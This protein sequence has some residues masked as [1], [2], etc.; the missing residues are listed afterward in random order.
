MT[1]QDFIIIYNETFRY[2]EE[3]FGRDKVD[4]LWSTISKQWCTHLRE[5]VEE[6]GLEGMLE[7][8]GGSEGT[9]NREKADYE[10][11]L[12]KGVFTIQMYNCPSVK[13]TKDKNMP[14]YK[15]YC[16]HCIALYVPIAE[17]NGFEMK[18]YIEKDK[19]DGLPLGR[20]KF[21]AKRKGADGIK[22]SSK[23]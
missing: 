3:K 22:S 16:E 7:Y 2:I 6:K 14:I 5:L 11:K 12:E 19:K 15:D 18:V 23:R 10:V 8:W 4:D 20:C 9:L 21:V 13:E 17:E 1:V